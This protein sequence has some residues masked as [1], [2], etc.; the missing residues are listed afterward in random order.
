[1]PSIAR[2]IQNCTQGH[3]D[4]QVLT[5]K[6]MFVGAEHEVAG[7]IPPRGGLRSADAAPKAGDR[8][9][10]DTRHIASGAVPKSAPR[11]AGQPPGDVRRSPSGAAHPPRGA[12]LPRFLQADHLPSQQS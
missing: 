2:Y 8:P 3:G 10:N 7:V 5:A 1:M 6:A 4:E 11:T 12:S 9:P